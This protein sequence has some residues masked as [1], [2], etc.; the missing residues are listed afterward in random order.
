MNAKAT[1]DSTATHAGDAKTGYNRFLLLVAGLGGPLYGVDL[2]RIGF[3][4]NRKAARG[5]EGRLAGNGGSI[6]TNG[7]DGI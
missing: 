1:I 7:H 6:K 3:Q 4:Q 5:R 2:H